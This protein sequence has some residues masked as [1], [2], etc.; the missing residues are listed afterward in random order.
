MVEKYL[1]SIQVLETK[2]GDKENLY[3]QLQTEYNSLLENSRK[4]EQILIKKH[5]L[6]Y[7]IGKENNKLRQEM[8][9]LMQEQGR[10]GEGHESGEVGEEVEAM[11]LEQGEEL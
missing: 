6:L 10:E 5:N 7:A 4:D 2:L 3:G 11:M 1:Q 9:R 8:A